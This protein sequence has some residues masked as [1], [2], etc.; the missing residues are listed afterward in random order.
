MTV[1][2]SNINYGKV[3]E[4]IND[5][6]DRD[7]RNVDTVS[8]ADTVIE[9]QAPTAA[10][11]YTWYRK[12]ASGWVEQGGI[13]LA[14]GSTATLPVEMADTNYTVLVSCSWETS[15]SSG[16]RGND[17]SDKTTTGFIAHVD[18]HSGTLNWEV[19][20]MAAS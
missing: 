18:N 12:Y 2:R 13:K 11:N 17:T 7:C 15:T 20:G 8:G 14:S 6:C 5:K 4:A 1:S 3:L 10:N 16:T 9:W 19:K